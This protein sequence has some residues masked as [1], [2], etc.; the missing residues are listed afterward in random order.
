MNLSDFKGEKVI[1]VLNENNREQFL[2]QAKGEGF[3][4]SLTKEIESGDDCTFR[5]LLDLKLRVI[6]NVSGMSYA[7]SRE[8]QDLPVY[9]FESRDNNL[10]K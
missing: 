8:L 2:A 3:R 7:H 9:Q 6:S 4:W 10:D 5:V 1:V